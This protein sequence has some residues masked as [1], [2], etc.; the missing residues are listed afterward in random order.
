MDFPRDPDQT[1]MGADFE[2]RA[3]AR[4]QVESAIE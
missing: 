4:V 2:A 1:D 3:S